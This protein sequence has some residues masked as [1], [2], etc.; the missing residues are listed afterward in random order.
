MDD[1]GYRLPELIFM[2]LYGLW[3][4]RCLN[5]NETAFN[6]VSVATINVSLV[7]LIRQNIIYASRVVGLIRGCMNNRGFTLIELVVVIVI[8]GVISSIA[9]PKFIN[10]KDDALKAN[11]KAMEASIKAATSMSSLKIEL[12]P[13]SLNGRQNRF[14][15]S[16][17]QVIRVRGM[18]PDGRWDSTFS[19]LVDFENI[20][21]V[22]TNNCTNTALAWCVRERG[23]GWFNSRGYA[24]LGTGRGFI[25]Y[26]LGFN[27]NQDRCY[28]Y[29]INQN[30]NATPATVSP[31]IT[32]SDFS[33]C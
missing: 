31:S 17:G 25:I 26:P 33:E 19:H 3:T 22:T 28:V 1:I 14:T 8:L 9:V 11:M 18:L 10:L 23:Q 15:L 21:Q 6:K 29:Y 24:S 12:N 7:L 13:D 2:G 30:A 32:G 16:N 27:V 5:D 20:A 4:S